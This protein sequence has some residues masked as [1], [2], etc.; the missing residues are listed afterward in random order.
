MSPASSRKLCLL[1]LESVTQAKGKA[2]VT[3][4]TGTGCMEEVEHGTPV[5]GNLE[6]NLV[7]DVFQTQLGTHA[8]A[9]PH[10]IRTGIVIVVGIDVSCRAYIEV[11]GTHGSYAE[12]VC[13]GNV[14]AAGI[15]P[16]KVHLEEVL[17]E[18]VLIGKFGCPSAATETD[19]ARLC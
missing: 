13:H 4:C 19:C 9:K 6:R 8:K 14:E 1:S 11:E 18:A 5:K 7:E 16:A 3:E 15:P 2:F 10:Y 12:V 17:A